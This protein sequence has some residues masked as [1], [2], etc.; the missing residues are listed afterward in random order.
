MSPDEWNRL[1]PL[2]RRRHLL[3]I[4]LS[5]RV[6]DAIAEVVKDEA[7][8]RRLPPRTIAAIQMGSSGGRRT[9]L[10]YLKATV[11]PFL[12]RDYHKD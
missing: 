6:L 7:E 11:N 12:P 3:A 1:P 4:G 9:R 8:A 2:I 10:L 5:S